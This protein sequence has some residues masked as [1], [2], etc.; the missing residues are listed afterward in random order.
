MVLPEGHRR[1]LAG[2]MTAAGPSNEVI[3][4]GI[5]S[6][7]LKAGAFVMEGLNSLATTYFFYYVYFYTKQAY[8]FDARQNFW[9]AAELGIVCAIGS[10]FGGKF[11]QKFGY[12]ASIRLGGAIMTACFLI[13]SQINAMWLTVLFFNIGTIG[14]CFTWAALQALVS[15][16]EPPMRLQSMIGI[17][18][19][20]WAATGAF[21]YFTG[22]AMM[23][24]WGLRAMF[25][26]PAGL[27]II[28]LILGYWLQKQVER[29]PVRTVDVAQPII[30]AVSEQQISPVSPKTFLL[31]AW[32]ANPFA[33]LAANTVISVTPSLA[34]H[35]NLTPK[36]AGFVYSVWMFARAG[37]FAFLRLW[38]K[39]HY[40]FR[41][42]AGAYAAMVLCFGLILF[43][44]QLWLLLLA[45]LGLGF[46]L[47]LIYYSSLFYSM[48]VGE[49]KGEHGGI[50]EAAIG[51]GSG[52][53][54]AIA[55][56]ALTVFPNQ[57]ASSTW[58]V[59]ALLLVGLGLLFW[60]RFRRSESSL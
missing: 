18:N 42:L 25:Y 11:A 60:M 34:G 53:G 27:L 12:F 14:M 1:N 6:P 37:S 2:E 57:P 10:F 48:D 20:T 46:G 59:V 23:D 51:A 15:E 36:I 44:S 52:F 55:A 28:Q 41:F 38:P 4:R 29:E 9:M 22:G 5:V 3:H 7:R 26:V 8:A 33:Y 21:A 31:M 58:A 45:E 17:Y 40:R 32:V 54:P 47:A 43:V 50:H 16:G 35:L 49:T 56:C 39:W 13:G 24:H 19:V 30:R